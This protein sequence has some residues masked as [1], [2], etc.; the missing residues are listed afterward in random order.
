M[1]PRHCMYYICKVLMLWFPFTL[2]PIL[3]IERYLR[4]VNDETEHMGEK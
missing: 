3:L 4:S 1:G 2:I